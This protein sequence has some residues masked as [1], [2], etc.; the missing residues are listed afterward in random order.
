[1][2]CRGRTRTGGDDRR[3]GLRD[4]ECGSAAL[5]VALATERT[6]Q[7]QEMAIQLGLQPGHHWLVTGPGEAL[8]S[9][10]PH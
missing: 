4:P 6:R 9:M 3:T 1:M 2:R 8:P 10:P 7:L 5:D